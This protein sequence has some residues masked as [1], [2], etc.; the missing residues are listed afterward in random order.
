MGE[1]VALW[2]TS[3][4]TTLEALGRDIAVAAIIFLAFLLLRRLF[5]RFVFKIILSLSSKTKTEVD[6]NILLAFENPFRAL[7]VIIGIYASLAYL[8]LT[9]YQN[10][11]LAKFFRSAL[12]V[13]I[14]WGVYNLAD[15]YSFKTIGKKFTLDQ[16]LTSFLSRVLKF[17]IIVLAVSVIV[18]EW[19]YDIDGLIAGLGLG[20]LAVALAARDTLANIFGGV[21]IIADKPF[22]VGDWIYTPSVEGTVEEVSFRST[23]VRTFANA[24]VTVPNSDLVNQPITNWS[25]MKKR[26]ITFH[27]GVTYSTPQDKLKKCVQTIRSMLE[28]HPAIHQETIF[29]RFDRFGDSSLDIFLY[30]FTNTTV[31]SEY[32]AVK[33]EINFKILEI[34][35]QEGVSVAFPSRSIYFETP[36]QYDSDRQNSASTGQGDGEPA[37]PVR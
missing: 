37:S 34:L 30:F 26:R 5:T 32:L 18:Q 20:G 9:D 21:V 13:L 17:V 3:A 7:I 25:R 24:L 6:D 1:T 16:T 15:N 35:E 8:P 12:I 31:W 2:V 23:K 14:A 19:G 28:T 22:A 11:L 36:L 10:L 4:V 29:V 27:L 33:E